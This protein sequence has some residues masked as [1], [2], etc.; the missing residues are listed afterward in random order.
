MAC[1][2]VSRIKYYMRRRYLVIAMD[3]ADLAAGIVFKRIVTAMNKYADCD[4]LC[5][6]IDDNTKQQVRSL[7]CSDFHRFHYRIE[8]W[9]GVNLGIRLSE[10]C[11]AEKTYRSSLS[12]VREG[13]YD[14]ILSFIYASN[15]SPLILG[16][17]LS[18]KIGLPWIVYTVDAI[19]LPLSWNPNEKQRNK[20]LRIIRKYV[21]ESDALFAAN[22]RMLSYEMECL[23][24]YRGASGVVL[25]PSENTTVS[26]AIRQEETDVVFL[27]AGQIYNIRRIGALLSGFRSLLHYHSKAKLVFV[28]NSQDEDYIGFEDLFN[29]G[30]VERYGF[31]KEIE[32]FY[33][34]ADVLLDINGDVENDVFLSSKICNYLSYSKPIVAISRDGSPVREMMSGYK[35]I[36]HCHHD[37][38]EICDALKEAISVLHTDFSERE[39]LRRQFSPGTVAEYF[40]KNL[41][42]IIDGKKGE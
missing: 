36:V 20:S 21:G 16:R 2:P 42:Q 40:C 1:I 7:P 12:K 18:T 6:T 11:W 15:L 24:N 3:M 38:E 23:K 29:K 14:A 5:P 22:P 27:Y 35:T 9:S 31:T 19:P 10:V 13:N 17:K 25:T 41:S 39:Y 34:N 26:K 30:R 8:R 37:Q 33:Q 32:P 4:V 28:G